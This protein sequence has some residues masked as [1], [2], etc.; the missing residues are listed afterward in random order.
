MKR[1]YQRS[2]SGGNRFKMVQEQYLKEPLSLLG[3]DV[4]EFE[5]INSQIQ[6]F[7][8]E[9]LNTSSTDGYVI[10]L[11]GGI[12]SA[13]VATLA[14]EAC[15]AD[16]VY[17]VIL[18]SKYSTDDDIDVAVCLA[19]KLGIGLNDYGKVRESFNP[20]LDMLV[21]SGEVNSD[22]YTQK[23]KEGNIQARMRMVLLRDIAKNRNSLVLGTTNMSEDI[24]GY[25]TIGGDGVGGIDNEGIS[26]MHKTTEKI[27]AQYLGVDSDIIN[28]TPTAG[29]WPGQTD[30][31]E[32]G[33][34][35]ENL[36]QILVGHQ[37]WLTP[38]QIVGAI[39]RDDVGISEVQKVISHV[40]KNRYKRMSI[41]TPDLR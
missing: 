19:D 28:R 10:G 5:K 27:F 34:T 6:E 40:G 20:I 35:Y 39:D 3:M 38:D 12:D 11:S 13:L 7:Y 2:Y 23:I 15:G 33:M 16:K 21:S 26:E 9:Q 29:L 17:G 24:M 22:P 36:D 37:L 18:P 31:D 32:L 30:E 14:V 4:A 8:Q 25:F 1:I 41:P